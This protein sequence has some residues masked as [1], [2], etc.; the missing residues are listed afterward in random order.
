MKLLLSGDLHIG[1]SSTR[2]PD[3]VR[4]DDLRAATV[5]RRIVEL[6]IGEQVAAV[7]LSGDVADQDNKFW[8][9]IGPLE[10]GL[11]RLAD[12]KIRTVAVA[13]NHDH[14]VLGRLADHL[15]HEHFTVLGRGGQ[16]ERITIH[17]GRSSLH[18]DGWSFPRQQVHH[19]PLERY[20]LPK[21][22]NT[23][24]LGI[25][26]GDLD[27]PTTPY[28]PL[29]LARL[30]GLPPTGWLLGHLHGYR[31]IGAQ[32]GR[33]VLYPGSPQ[34]L[35]PG[36]TGPHGPWIVEISSSAMGVPEHWPLSRIWYGQCE[37]N[38]STASNESEIE[39]VVLNGIRERTAHIVA[40]AGPHLAHISLRLKLVGT[41]RASH[42]VREVTSQL[43][44]NLSL[45]IGNATVG[46]E[47]V[48]VET[49]PAID[50][51]EH[52]NSRSAPGAL[53]RL[54]LELEQP[55]PSQDLAELIH[56]ARRELENVDQHKDFTQ[57]ERREV[58]EELARTYLRT[59]A[60]RLLT[61]LVNQTA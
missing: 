4:P 6:A 12:A 42:H 22:S 31:L 55:K 20:N 29:D 1:R 11:L 23:P 18:L 2:V 19:S 3:S 36:E 43:I 51:A 58:T 7:C 35:D 37:I 38:L 5:W 45:P 48:D 28:A 39:S 50:L 16:W 24:I 60:R 44:H 52:A 10:E 9:A 40:T 8:E 25:V 46:V 27:S 56:R 33:W 57:L 54:L 13:G 15:P 17:H 61:Q 41:T 59:Q 21:D 26:H 49:V 30:Q 14:D 53:A 47:S 34:A 32:T